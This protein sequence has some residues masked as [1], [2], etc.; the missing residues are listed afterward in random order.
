MLVAPLAR[1]Q[2]VKQM[3]AELKQRGRS[4][5]HCHRQVFSALGQLYTAGGA[6]ALSDQTAVGQSGGQPVPAEAPLPA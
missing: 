4:E 2:E 3:V 1:S 5:Y 6:A